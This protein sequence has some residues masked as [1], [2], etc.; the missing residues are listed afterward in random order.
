MSEWF[1]EPTEE[2]LEKEKTRVATYDASIDKIDEAIR[3]FHKAGMEVGEHRGASMVT[4]WVTV[5]AT[6][7]FDDEGVPRGAIHLLGP[8][9]TP[10]WQDI[11]LLKSGLQA[12]L[13]VP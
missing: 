11:G 8:R 1:E 13:D 10:M 5:M 12:A 9:S 2:D 4:A 6:T 3:A 7:R